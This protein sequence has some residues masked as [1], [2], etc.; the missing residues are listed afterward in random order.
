MKNKKHLLDAIKFG[1]VLLLFFNFIL[2]C[3]GFL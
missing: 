3:T 2:I 1:G